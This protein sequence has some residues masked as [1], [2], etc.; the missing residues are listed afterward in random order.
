MEHKKIQYKKNNTSCVEITRESH[1]VSRRAE[2]LN[3]N[4]L[5][6]NYQ[7]LLQS[8]TTSSCT[9][10]LGRMPANPYYSKRQGTRCNQL[11]SVIR[12]EK[13]IKRRT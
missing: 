1:H 9:V 8:N 3:K 13:S 12:E 7:Q 11:Y 6:L 4:I 10:A 2:P 5:N